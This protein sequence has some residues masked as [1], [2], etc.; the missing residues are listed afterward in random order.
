VISN[1]AQSFIDA[2]VAQ[3]KAFFA[4]VGV[5]APHLPI[6]PAPRDL[7][8]Y[9]GLKAPRPPSFNEADVSDKPHWIR[10]L[11]ILSASQ[12]TQLD[13]RQEARAETLQALD[14]LVEGVVN[15]IQPGPP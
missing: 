7:N 8:T 12:I 3:G 6:T 5:A 1:E 4:Y 10:S 2:S 15:N 9:D 14:D 13:T 11:S